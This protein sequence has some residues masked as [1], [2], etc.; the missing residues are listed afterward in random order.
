LRNFFRGGAAVE[1]I[2]F[3]ELQDTDYSPGNHSLRCTLADSRNRSRPRQR[4]FSPPFI[5]LPFEDTFTDFIRERFSLPLKF[6]VD[7]F[8]LLR[9]QS[10]PCRPRLAGDQQSFFPSSLLS[11][12]VDL[13]NYPSKKG[14][15]LF[16]FPVT[17]RQPARAGNF[18]SSDRTFFPCLFPLFSPRSPP[19]CHFSSSMAPS[20]LPY[21]EDMRRQSRIG[22][23]SSGRCFA[24]PVCALL[25]PPL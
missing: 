24:P 17:T 6:Y 13:I 21:L 10:L 23:R 2:S 3:C 20:T 8:T 19:S 9:P 25:P 12:I 15:R 5:L 18:R 1:I 7:P 14:P 16:F 22:L 11:F 4:C